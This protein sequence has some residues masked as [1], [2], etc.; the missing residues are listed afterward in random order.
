[1]DLSS[2]LIETLQGYST[3]GVNGYTY[4]TRND[5]NTRFAV[6]AVFKEDKPYSFLCING[7]PREKIILA[8]AGETIATAD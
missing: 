6:I 8:Y 7:I 1:M 3:Q 4:L 5:E 2:I